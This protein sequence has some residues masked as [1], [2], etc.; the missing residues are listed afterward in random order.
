M[1]IEEALSAYLLAHASVAALAGTRGYPNVVPQ[2]VALPNWAY[3]RISGPELM[4]H[5]GNAKLES[6]RFQFTCHGD[7]YRDAKNLARAI[8]AALRGY[9]GLM[10]GAG[11]VNVEGIYV[12]GEY[13]GYNEQSRVQTV[14][15]DA[16]VWYRP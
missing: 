2:E 8:R 10:G 9:R 1:I 4:D 5:G 12:I 6:G 3:Q 11:G 7:E 13:D 14:R 16:E 15:L